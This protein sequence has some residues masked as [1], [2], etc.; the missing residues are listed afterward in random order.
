VVEPGIC[1]RIMEIQNAHTTRASIEKALLTK[2]ML[3]DLSRMTCHTLMN[4]IEKKG[5]NPC[6]SRVYTKFDQ[7]YN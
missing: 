7:K 2:Y 1:E 6:A 5:K 3:E 4:W